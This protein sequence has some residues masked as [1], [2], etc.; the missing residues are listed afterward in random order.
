MYNFTSNRVITFSTGIHIYVFLILLVY[1]N[2]FLA[3]YFS[4][5][6]FHLHVLHKFEHA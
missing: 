4:T 1:V 2:D 6:S 5:K 3:E